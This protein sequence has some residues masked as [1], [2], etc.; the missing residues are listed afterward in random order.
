MGFLGDFWMFLD[1]QGA[2]SSALTPG[3][4]G[5][6]ELPVSPKANQ[7]QVAQVPWG[8]MGTP[9][10]CC[11]SLQKSYRFLRYSRPCCSMLFPTKIHCEFPTWK[12]YIFMVK[13]MVKMPS[14]NTRSRSPV[15]TRHSPG[16]LKVP[17]AW[18]CAYD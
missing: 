6:E 12:S 16:R 5:Q 9:H 3:C 18:L 11:K 7:C 4:V 2:E 8:S 13:I 14:E 10:S 1:T 17:G 15:W